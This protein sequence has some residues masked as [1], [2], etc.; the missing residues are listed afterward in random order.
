MNLEPVRQSKVSQKEKKKQVSYINA[1]MESRK[2]VLI[3]PFSG[4]E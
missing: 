3:N 1:Y 2:M 4:K